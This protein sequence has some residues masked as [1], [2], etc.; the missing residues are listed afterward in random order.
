MEK[1][2]LN[3]NV[4]ERSNFRFQLFFR[5]YLVHLQ[6]EPGIWC[7]RLSGDSCIVKSLEIGSFGSTDSHFKK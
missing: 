7:D 3:L 1:E 5:W 4:S 2:K 6:V